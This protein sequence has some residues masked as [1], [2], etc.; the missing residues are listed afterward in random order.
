MYN[1]ERSF[2]FAVKLV[3]EVDKISL[4]KKRAISTNIVKEAIEYLLCNKQADLFE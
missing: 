4:A 2:S 1:M 3:E